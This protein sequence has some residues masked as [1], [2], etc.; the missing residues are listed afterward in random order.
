MLL[1]VRRIKQRGQ[2]PALLL[3]A[4]SIFVTTGCGNGAGSAATPPDA[5]SPDAG[6]SAA[7]AS[8]TAK[9]FSNIDDMSGWG[10]CGSSACAGGRGS[11][12]YWMA[13][14]QTTPSMDGSS[15]EFSN[16]GVYDNALFW[17]KLGA[18]NW[19][20]N[21]LWDFYLRVDDASVGAA[22]NL[23]FDVFQFMGGYKYIMGSQCNYSAG[24]WDIWNQYAYTSSTSG[25]RHTSIPCPKFTA[26][27]WHHIQWYVQSIPS[28]HSYKYISLVV[29]GHSHAIN[30]T[31]RAKYNGVNDTVGVQWQLD[32]NASGHRYHEWVDKAKLSIW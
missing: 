27:V 21:L 6:V 26:N 5:G 7:T 14:Y 31:Y 23:E 8:S 9:V 29:D 2:T 10:S 1:E 28:T 18:N 24:V 32:V 13:R 17:K 25:W 19:A 20:R 30:Q 15:V 16:S 11:S 3:T 4:F 12:S 22:Q